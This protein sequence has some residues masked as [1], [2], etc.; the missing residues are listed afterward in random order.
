MSLDFVNTEDAMR[1]HLVEQHGYVPSALAG[2]GYDA[3]AAVHRDQPKPH[4][5]AAERD[6]QIAERTQQIA[7][8]SAELYE[9]ACGRFNAI[10]ETYDKRRQ[11][12]RQQMAALDAEWEEAHAN[13]AMHED[14]GGI[15]L[16]NR[17][18]RCTPWR[19]LPA[20]HAGACR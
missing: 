17:C 3:L 6:A 16:Y 18:P 2:M 4:R 5:H 9:A 11:E 14:T 8:T 12:L 13:L 10:A 1:D 7:A 15:P 19:A 20:Q